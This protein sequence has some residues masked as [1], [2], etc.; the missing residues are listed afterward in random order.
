[1]VKAREEAARDE[2]SAPATW[3]E[4]LCQECL[5]KLDIL[6]ECFGLLSV[7]FPNARALFCDGQEEGAR[8]GDD[9]DDDRVSDGDDGDDGD[10]N[11]DG[12]PVGIFSTFSNNE[13]VY[14]ILQSIDS[15]GDIPSAVNFQSATLDLKALVEKVFSL[16]KQWTLLKSTINKA[17]EKTGPNAQ[18]ISSEKKKAFR[19]HDDIVE[20]MGSNESDEASLFS[21]FRKSVADL[22]EVMWKS[23]L[24]LL[25]LGFRTKA[26]GRLPLELWTGVKA[27]RSNGS[28]LYDKGVKEFLYLF[29][30]QYV[31]CIY[32]MMSCFLFA[33]PIKPDFSSSDCLMLLGSSDVQCYINLAKLHLDS[34]FNAGEHPSADIN[35]AIFRLMFNIYY[36]SGSFSLHN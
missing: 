16:I 12:S 32:K 19:E 30:P 26:T 3:M 20:L 24:H 27:D 5:A 34:V 29:T 17:S 1:L 9:D 36:Y 8:N 28:L 10:D 22:N 35:F 4:T 2:V 15:H 18:K 11:N 23:E 7:K 33:R 25:F 6:Q 31:G 21:K 14:E 13:K